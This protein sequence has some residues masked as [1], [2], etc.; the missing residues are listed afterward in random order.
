MTFLM[1]SLVC[2]LGSELE[3]E[4][5]LS[6]SP[7]RHAFCSSSY[8]TENGLG[9]VDCEFYPPAVSETNSVS[10]KLKMFNLVSVT[11]ESV[12]KCSANKELQMTTCL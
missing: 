5:N 10:I 1:Q 6:V 12:F 4:F 11:H 3:D 7:Q 2:C 9:S 8:S